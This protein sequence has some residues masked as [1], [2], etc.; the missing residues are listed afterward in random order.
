MTDFNCRVC[1]QPSGHWRHWPNI[2]SESYMPPSRAQDSDFHLFES[3]QEDNVMAI[4][5]I[6][7]EPVNPC[8]EKEAA[9]ILT[10]C[11]QILDVVRQEWGKENCWSSWDQSVRDAATEWLRRFYSMRCTH[12]D[13]KKIGGFNNESI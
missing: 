6:A 12:P 5:A 10:D 2:P 11:C 7:L 4:E 9:D 8:P 3:P 1:G 13:Q